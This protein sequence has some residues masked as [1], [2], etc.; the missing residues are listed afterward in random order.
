MHLMRSTSH[1]R[2]VATAIV[3]VAA[4]AGCDLPVPDLATPAPATPDATGP[5]VPP[6][7]VARP[8]D[9]A[10]GTR[11]VGRGNRATAPPARLSLPA[12]AAYPPPPGSGPFPAPVD[13]AAAGTL[14]GSSPDEPPVVPVAA[15]CAGIVQRDGERLVLDGQPVAFFGINAHY[16]LDREFPEAQVDFFLREM[17]RREVNAVRVWFF[18]DEDPDRLERLLDAGR[19]HGLR[20]VVTLADHVFK[21]V[22]WFGDDEDEDDY[23]PHMARTVERFK[24]RPEILMWELINE[25][26]CGEG[27]Y[28]AECAERIKGWLRSRAREVAAIDAC[29]V[30]STGMIGAGNF[31]EERDAFRRVHREDGIGIVSAHRRVDERRDVTLGIAGEIG[32]PIFYGEVYARGHDEGCRP[33]EGDDS[34]EQRAR[35][36]LDDLEDA[37]EEGVDGYLLWAL[38]A[39]RIDTRD[40]EKYYCGVNDY[41]LDD[42]LWERLEAD[43]E[44][45]P[46]VPWGPEP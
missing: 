1:G 14:D 32:R 11:E 21:T 28:S 44:L 31:D 42:P 30:V 5:A 46:P 7:D 27:R 26:S 43:P 39:G 13:D 34:P 9:S 41:E 37:L 23:R 10:V 3:L 6:A 19:R 36:V 33:L 45:P 29:H 16:L 38:A 18:H 25:P 20:F 35:R 2:S 12:L 22:D 40:G 8:V 4:V 15:D 17:A 24:A